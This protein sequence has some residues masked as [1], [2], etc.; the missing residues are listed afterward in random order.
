MGSEREACTIHSVWA[1]QNLIILCYTSL[2]PS[3]CVCVCVCVC[4][5]LGPAGHAEGPE[6]GWLY[7]ET[8][9]VRPRRVHTPPY[10]PTPL[11]GSAGI[12]TCWGWD[13]WPECERG[14]FLLARLAGLFN[15]ASF[16]L[17]LPLA[18]WKPLQRHGVP[19]RPSLRCFCYYVMGPC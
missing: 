18:E 19:F 15:L 3:V 6:Q 17:P 9:W 5:P 16:A 10:P 14:H 4:Q 11:T 12:T 7:R 2:V 1:M 13:Y 8:I